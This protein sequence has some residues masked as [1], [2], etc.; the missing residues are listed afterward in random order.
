MININFDNPYLLLLI[1]PLAALVLV[2]YFIAIRKENKSIASTVALITHLITV[3]IVILAAAGMSN[4]TVI[5]ETEVLVVADVS[6]SADGSLDTVDQYIA[7]IEKNL[8]K[9]SKLGVVTFGKNYRLHTPFGGE[10]TSVKESL[11]NKSA[12]DLVS[13]LNYAGTCFSDNAIKRIVVITDGMFTDPSATGALAN[14]IADLKSDGV[15]VDAIYL[16]SALQGDAKEIQLS[17]VDFM[18]S[19]HVGKETTANVLIESTFDTRIILSLVKDGI[20]CGEKAVEI[21]AGYNIVNFDLDTGSAGE[22]DYELTFSSQEDTSAKNNVLRFTQSIHD[23]LKVLLIS[24]NYT[25]EAIVRDLYGDFAE[26]TAYAPPKAQPPKNP[27]QPVFDPPFEVPVTVEEL[28]YYDEIIISNLDISDVSKCDTLIASLDTVVSLFGKTLITVGNNH[29]QNSESESLKSFEDLLPIRFGNSDADPKLY[30]LVIDCSRSMVYE[31]AFFFENA[32]KSAEQIINMLG[33]NDSFSIITFA[34]EVYTAQLPMAATEE[35]KAK[36]ISAIKALGVEQGTMIGSAL[37]A[38]CEFMSVLNYD[39]KRLM[40][41]SDGL[42]FSG[43]SGLADDPEEMAKKLYDNGICVSTLN[44][45][46]IYGDA[47]KDGIA[48]LQSIAKKGGG[49]Y[50]EFEN[51][52]KIDDKIFGDIADDVNNTEIIGR[53]EVLINKKNNDVLEGVD[54]LGTITGYIYSKKK[55]SADTILSTVYTKPSGN[56]VEVPIYASWS[57]G[58][59]RVATLTTTLGGDWVRSWQNGDGQTFL[60]NIVLSNIPD[61]RIDHPYTVNVEYDGRYSYIEIIPAVVNP[62]ATMNVSVVF[63][64]GSEASEILTFDSNRYF[65]KVETGTTGKYRVI[66]S[67]D[68]STKSYVSESVYTISYSPEYDSFR[69]CSP[70]PLYAMMRD[71]GNVYE[72]SNVDFTIEDGKIA[73]YVLKFTVPFLAA[74][75]V[76]FVI[77][78]IIRKLQWVDIVSLFKRKNKG[79]EK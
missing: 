62:D 73:T 70:A 48:L 77:D 29:I 34:G 13:A 28:C 58:T 7:D 27:G 72:D 30:T 64:D 60:K 31:R 22:F 46:N 23:G 17:S 78:T 40:L 69:V 74:A 19:T 1:I 32:K 56:K 16:N 75:A 65:F 47:G 36:A 59:G 66:T 61:Q 43:G 20:P 55:A 37:D 79:A 5:T 63:P 45:G 15:Y 11:V 76:L 68:W 42:S 53:V 39:E 6:Y 54:S 18:P 44:P 24:G 3:V 50:F 67:Y 33:E 21:T 51:D 14:T 9:N 57:Y 26:I 10:V 4:V 38:A 52:E 49:A 71:N 35:N 8:P 12:T 41:I 2:P 25:D